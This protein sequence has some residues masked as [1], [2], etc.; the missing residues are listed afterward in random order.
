MQTRKQLLA[1]SLALAVSGAAFAQAAPK[2]TG[3]PLTESDVRAL[4]ANAGYTE[5]NDVKFKEGVWT[6]DGR[7]ADG[8]H[9]EVKVDAGGKIIPDQHVA[10]ISKDQIIIM[11]QQAGYKNVHDVDFEG[12]VW[13]VEADA[14]DGTDVE[15]KMDPD[16]GHILGSEADRVQ[17]HDD[18][19]EDN[20]ERADDTAEDNAER[21][22]RDATAE[23]N[24]ERAARDDKPEE[25]H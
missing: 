3:S 24:A 13:K 8:N 2:N 19:A 23:D 25:H 10:T 9:V 17:N 1:L 12:G 6:A 21:A 5:V 14:A 7:S 15:L 4:M 11:A 22:A 16:D 20:A 18:T